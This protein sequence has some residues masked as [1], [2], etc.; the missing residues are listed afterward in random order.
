MQCQ[1]SFRNLALPGGVQV[2][3]RTPTGKAI[4]Q[5]VVSDTR[6][7]TKTQNNAGIPPDQQNLLGEKQLE[8]FCFP[9][10]YNVQEQLRLRDGPHI[11]VNTPPRI[12]SEA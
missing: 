8:G 9:S 6:Q 7:I 11:F 10:S 4:C 3:V 12:G 1:E 5:E 2:H